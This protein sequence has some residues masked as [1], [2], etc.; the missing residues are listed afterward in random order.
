MVFT[1]I[2]KLKNRPGGLLAMLRWGGE[3][4]VADRGEAEAELRQPENRHEA[5]TYRELVRH[6]RSG[7][8]RLG[9]PN[10]A[11]LYP[12]IPRVLP[13]GTAQRLLDE[14]RGER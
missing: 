7:M 1:V 12:R 8:V 3:S 5:A 13:P 4:L 2:R 11:D 10:R 14:E 6:A 9:A